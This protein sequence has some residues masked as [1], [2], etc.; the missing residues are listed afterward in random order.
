MFCPASTFLS[1]R[2]V[3][4]CVAALCFFSSRRRHT[5]CALVTGVQT[6]APPISMAA[7]TRSVVDFLRGE[8]DKRRDNPPDDAF[9]FALRAQVEGRPLTD[10]ELVGFTFNLFIGGL[11]TVST[12]MEIGR[13][14]V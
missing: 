4:R 11:D 9:G 2:S 14:H 12:N 7:A 13:A 1:L 5:R 3:L 10:D 6:C 8:L